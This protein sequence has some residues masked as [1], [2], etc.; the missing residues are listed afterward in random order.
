MAL[1]QKIFTKKSRIENLNIRDL[2]ISEI[3][4]NKKI[5]EIQREIH[6]LEE[7]VTSYFSE[8]KSARSRSEE[9]SIAVRIDTATKKRETK[10]NAQMQLE[11]ELRAITNIL[12]LKEH[13]KDL[14]SAGVWDAIGPLE[15][16]EVEG[17][18]IKKNLAAESHEGLIREITNM[19]EDAMSVGN[20]IEDESLSEILQI[21]DDV[22]S[23]N[24]EPMDAELKT[25]DRVTYFE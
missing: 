3:Q 25:I 15:P 7:R 5:S 1:L 17:W 23:G 8:A 18:L 21:I 10:L 9:I 12:T 13:E 4:L 24:L 20:C 2:K 11:K 16:D 22:K 19:T 6:I 14:Q